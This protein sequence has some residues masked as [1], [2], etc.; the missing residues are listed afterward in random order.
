MKNYERENN[1]EIVIAKIAKEKWMKFALE[2]GLSELIAEDIFTIF[3]R[4]YSAP[5][6][7]YHNFEHIL[8]ILDLINEA[9]DDVE[10]LKT[11]YLAVWFHD[12][13]YRMNENFD[14]EELSA[15][16]AGSFLETIL[17][18]EV[19]KIKAMIMS[20]KNHESSDHD[21][22]ILIDADLAILGSSEDNYKKYVKSIREEY[23]YISD[24]DFRIGRLQVLR[25]ILN[26][27][28][29]FTTQYFK[30]FEESARRN[31]ANEI[32]ELEK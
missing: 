18:Q 1:P 15:R 11:L 32:A 26:K 3:E 23:D 20:T 6:R 17:P 2:I 12:V 24:K 4:N 29:I 22:Q 5:K 7:K 28:Y 9:K 31:I 8:S 25:K 21:S 19:E 10:D 16:I 13:I 27:P 30:K 14:N